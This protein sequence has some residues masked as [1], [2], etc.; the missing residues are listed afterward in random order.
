[1]RIFF[2]L[3][4][5]IYLSFSTY[6][7]ATKLINLQIDEN[8]NTIFQQS[9]PI[10]YYRLTHISQSASGNHKANPYE[11]TVSI[12]PNKKVLEIKYK[13]PSVFNPPDS[14]DAVE[15]ISLS[16]NLDEILKD[17]EG[18]GHLYGIDK[19]MKD[20]EVLFRFL[21]NIKTI[22]VRFRILGSSSIYFETIYYME[23]LKQ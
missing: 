22:N 21:L 1:M 4:T 18:S 11:G 3:F 16:G 19:D 2:I 23:D 17:E 6:P 13:V 5:F 9:K 10:K 8:G 12:D 14:S 15:K 20:V 7:L